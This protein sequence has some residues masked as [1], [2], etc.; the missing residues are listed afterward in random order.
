MKPPI[1]ARLGLALAMGFTICSAHA[2]Q[3]LE[4][5][6][7]EQPKVKARTSLAEGGTPVK[8]G[9]AS[10]WQRFTL[11]KIPE[12]QGSVV[13]GLTNEMAR[14]GAQSLFV[15]FK[16]LKAVNAGVTLSSQLTRIKA[17]AK[18]R[19]SLWG[20]VD[21]KNPLTFDQRF[22]FLMLVVEFYAAD[23]E[24]QT[25]TPMFQAQPLP[26]SPN[27]S[28]KK[29]PLFTPEAW[30][31]YFVEV[32]TPSDAEYIKVTW[33]W[34]SA[35]DAGTTNGAM[36]FDDAT[37]HGPAAPEE[38]EEPAPAQE[39]ETKPAADAKAKPAPKP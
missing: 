7:F 30:S 9:M 33:K 16:K 18:Y 24:T 35:N 34:Q 25:G 13:T 28:R 15:E 22:P 27:Y 32:E 21:K 23:Q 14:T 2:D 4:S 5:A 39:P 8:A 10:S 31:E 3:L 17:D 38:A 1:S 29:P 36:F 6:S 26:D 12:D 11:A 20:R 19:L 37:L